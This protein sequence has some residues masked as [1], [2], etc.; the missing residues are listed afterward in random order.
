MGVRGVAREW[1]W[2]GARLA[3]IVVAR[4][5][6]RLIPAVQR[7]VPRVPV[8]VSAWDDGASSSPR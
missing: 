5:E 3:P 2:V 1:A 6:L 4:R 8:L 7:E